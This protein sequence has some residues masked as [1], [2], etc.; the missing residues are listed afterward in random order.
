[1]RF[2]CTGSAIRHGT[3]VPIGLFLETSLPF[4]K[5]C[6][7]PGAGAFAKACG[8]A[9]LFE[10]SATQRFPETRLTVNNIELRRNPSVDETGVAR[11]T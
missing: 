8:G 11:D 2:A 10:E 3:T 1:M 6:R 9:G 7:G 5:A 4:P